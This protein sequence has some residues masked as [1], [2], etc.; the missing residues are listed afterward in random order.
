MINIKAYAAGN[1]FVADTHKIRIAF[2]YLATSSKGA[3]RLILLNNEERL[4]WNKFIA[5]L[6]MTK[7]QSIRSFE[8]NFYHYHA[9]PGQPCA[10]NSMRT[11]ELNETEIYMIKRRFIDFSS[12][13]LQNF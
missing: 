8:I 5:K 4:D 12:R 9:K 10:L 6:F 7:S 11:Q 1:G 2:K 3:D 13:P